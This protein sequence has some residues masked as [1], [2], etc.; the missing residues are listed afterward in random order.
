MGKAIVD[1]PV[2]S[3]NTE[4]DP[5]GFLSVNDVAVFFGLPFLGFVSGL[6]PQSLWWGVARTISPLSMKMLPSPAD[7]IRERARIFLGDSIGEKAL[8]K[9]PHDLAANEI[10]RLFL[11]LGALMPFDG[12]LKTPLEGQ[13]HI[14]AALEKGKGVILWDS[15]FY[16]ANSA[17]KMALQRAGYKTHHLSHARHGFSDTWIGMKLLNP[18]WV[19][20]EFKFL[21]ERVVIAYDNPAPAMKT[22][23]ARLD[24][25]Q[26][27]SVTVRDSAKHPVEVPFLGGHLRVAPGAP[28]MAKRHGAALVPVFTIR[29]AD[30]TYVTRA[31]APIDLPE[32]LDTRIAVKSAV[33]QYAQ[34]LEPVVRAY[35]DQWVDW[36][37]L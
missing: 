10:S 5:V 23:G 14:D 26:V 35:P 28:V 20:S 13:E 21:A 31:E 33:E 17:T 18:L 30:G 24:Q 37:S 22:L 16:F 8:Q 6:I 3:P 29:Q 1:L 19:A 4:D 32:D 15:H 2:Q 25:N 34:R 9:F 11:L 7:H 12:R 27:V 36:L